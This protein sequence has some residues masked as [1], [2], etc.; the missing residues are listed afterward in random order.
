[1]AES[2]IPQQV[3][4]R[5]S[6]RARR[7]DLPEVLVLPSRVRE[8]E[9]YYSEFDIDAVRVARSAGVDVEFLDGADDRRYLSEYSAGVVLSFAVSVLQDLSV[10]G[11]K[12]IGSFF[13]AQLSQV[14][15]NR[16][17]SDPHDVEMRIKV[18]AIR[19]R[20]DE[21]EIKGLEVEARGVEAVSRLLPMLGAPA[22]A[23]EALRQLDVPPKLPQGSDSSSQ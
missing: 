9:S 4:E 12:A 3:I 19:V 17:A 6:A 8:G 21:I 22:A 13:L 11:L 18:A 7:G 2:S 14:L 10:E 15:T 5:V 1:M 23:A 16:T 20:S